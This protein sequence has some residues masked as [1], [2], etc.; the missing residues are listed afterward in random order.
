MPCVY[1]M[2]ACRKTYMQRQQGHRHLMS[3]LIMAVSTSNLA[4]AQTCIDCGNF[5]V[6]AKGST[7]NQL[8][9]FT[10]VSPTEST[11]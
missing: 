1:C 9:E 5:L 6:G 11:H 3:D 7:G 10:I 4:T 2:Y 8:L